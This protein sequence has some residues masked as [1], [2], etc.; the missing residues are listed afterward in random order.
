M[1]PYYPREHAATRIRN[2]GPA[3]VLLPRV[4]RE[5]TIAL[6]SQPCLR[7]NRSLATIR[8]YFYDPTGEKAGRTGRG[9]IREDAAGLRVTTS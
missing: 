2:R 1:V 3:E 8:A 5:R 6:S 4:D 7:L 9:R